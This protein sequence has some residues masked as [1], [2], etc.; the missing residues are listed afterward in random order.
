MAANGGRSAVDTARK[1]PNAFTL[2]IYN[3]SV[4][5]CYPSQGEAE[6]SAKGL[7][8]TRSG[9][10]NIEGLYGHCRKQFS[11]SAHNLFSATYALLAVFNA[12]LTRIR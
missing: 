2:R 11:I 4:W 5:S 9:D 7:R 12:A 6:P 1:G 10:E 3:R 8:A